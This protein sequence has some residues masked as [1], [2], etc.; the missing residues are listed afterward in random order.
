VLSSSLTRLA[1][2]AL[3]MFT[4]SLLGTWASQL[5]LRKRLAPALQRKSDQVNSRYSTRSAASLFSV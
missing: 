2:I 3:A 1:W 5:A 4:V